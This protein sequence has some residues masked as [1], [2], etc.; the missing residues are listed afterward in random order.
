MI[1]SEIEAFKLFDISIQSFL[2]DAFLCHDPPYL[3]SDAYGI[4]GIAPCLEQVSAA[5]LLA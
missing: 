1:Q 5:A 3:S 2:K 4:A